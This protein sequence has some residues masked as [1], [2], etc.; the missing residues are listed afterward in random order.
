VRLEVKYS[1]DAEWRGIPA[2]EISVRLA[3]RPAAARARG[4]DPIVRGEGARSAILYL[5]KANNQPLF[6]RET[7]SGETYVKASGKT[8]RLDGF[9]LSFFFSA[10]QGTEAR[11]ALQAEASARALPGVSVKETERGLSLTLENLRFE[12]DSPR[13]LAGEAERLDKMAAL[14]KTLPPGARFLVRGHTALAGDEAERQALSV[15]RARAVIKELAARGLDAGAFLYEGVGAR[16]PV[17]DN[18]TEDGRAL[19]RRVEIIVLK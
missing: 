12:A 2:R 6:C 18:G 7:L 17:A 3:L 14:L 13:L 16:E 4:A 15:E 9:I 19:N 5:D 10:S 11:R 8:R 1:R